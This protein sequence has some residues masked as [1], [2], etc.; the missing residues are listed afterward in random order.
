M[1]AALRSQ[2]ALT[3]VPGMGPVHAKLLLNFFDI[4]EIFEGDRTLLQQCSVLPERLLDSLLNFSNWKRVEEE[5]Q[6]I[7]RNNIQ[8]LFI[9]DADYPRRL[10]TCTDA[11]VLL[12]YKGQ[13]ALNAQRMV[14]VVGTRGC[15]R[16]GV[17]FTEEIVAQL[18]AYSVTII[19]GLA[20][21]IDTVAHQ[22]ALQSGLPTLAVLP[23][24]LDAIYPAINRP[25][26]REILRSQGGLLTESMT[27]NKGDTYLFP[28]RNRIV[29]GCCDTALIIESGIKGGSLI[30]A[31]LASDYGR[32]VFALPGRPSDPKSQG[33]HRLIKQQ[34]AILFETGDEVAAWMGWEKSNEL[35]QQK[36]AKRKN[37]EAP[38]ALN[39]AEARLLH[40]IS[41]ATILTID[42]LKD[43]SQYEPQELAA[44]LINLELAGLIVSLPGNRYQPA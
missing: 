35:T 1:E 16:Q 13:A 17:R 44:A 8:T 24:G 11:P 10:L 29:A 21:G 40:Y 4:E 6:F 34:R 28:R 32:E 23:L 42:Q 26:A 41:N 30:T 25:L 7:G 36:N 19:S 22:S 2:I 39:T 43:W 12:Y 33:C 18:A 3:M 37:T 38:T 31:G 9:T 15:T 20:I 27:K 14:A 5:I